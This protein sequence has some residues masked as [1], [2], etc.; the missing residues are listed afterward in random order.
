[1]EDALVLAGTTEQTDIRYQVL[2]LVV[3]EDALV[4]R[5][6]WPFI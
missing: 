2:I 4:Q 1:M 3:M 6:K 5:Q